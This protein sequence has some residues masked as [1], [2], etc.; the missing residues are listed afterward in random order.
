MPAV[1][2]IDPS[3]RKP[4]RILRGS[5]A[6]L[7]DYYVVAAATPPTAI[8]YTE[9]GHD[10]APPVYEI[11]AAGRKTAV[12]EG[13]PILTLPIADLPKTLEGLIIDSDT[14]VPRPMSEAEL[15]EDVERNAPTWDDY[16]IARDRL[17]SG[18]NG[19]LAGMKAF[20]FTPVIAADAEIKAQYASLL[21]APSNPDLTPAQGIQLIK[22]AD[23]QL[24]LITKRP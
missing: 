22:D 4:I 19:T 9:D 10:V 11:D 24:R 16:R 13:D 23:A 21:A 15:A 20:G 2:L 7:P 14:S 12:G 8:L 1:L 17:F 18:W 3:T 6:H 5:A